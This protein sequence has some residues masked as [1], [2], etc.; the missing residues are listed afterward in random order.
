M[1][2]NA[3]NWL[4]LLLALV[5]IWQWWL[6]TQPSMAQAQHAEVQTCTGAMPAALPGH[7]LAAVPPTS[8]FARQLCEGLRM[9][10]Q[11]MMDAPLTGEA[12]HDFL[13][14]MIP[15]HQGAID[16]AK[17]VLLHGRDERVRRLAQGIIIEQQAEIDAMRR[18]LNAS[19]PKKERK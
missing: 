10:H 4:V 6:M 1:K 3:Q 16:M 7:H 12:D 2:R 5:V 11:E 14:L 17:L 13:A 15:H 19:T 9:M 8:L 18:L